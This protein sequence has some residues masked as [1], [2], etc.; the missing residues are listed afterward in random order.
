VSAMHV[1]LLTGA[2]AVLLAAVATMIMLARRPQA[3]SAN[4]PARSTV[5]DAVA[6]AEI[7]A[8]QHV[9]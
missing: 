5:A 1:A 9:S 3:M 6:S 8:P 2:G 4:E 7:T